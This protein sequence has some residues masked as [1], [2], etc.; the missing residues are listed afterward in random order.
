MLGNIFLQGLVA[1][2]LIAIGGAL[3]AAGAA[4]APA[5]TGYAGIPAATQPTQDNGYLPM[6]AG[7]HGRRHD[8]RHDDHKSWEKQGK[9]P[10]APVKS[11]RDDD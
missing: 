10:A 1:A 5:D 7:K 6:A 9:R 2:G 11:R 4:E 8:D 3:Y